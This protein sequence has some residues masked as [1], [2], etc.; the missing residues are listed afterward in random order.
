MVIVALIFVGQILE[1]RARDRVGDAIRALLDLAPKTAR[2]ITSEGEEQDAPLS[3]IIKGDRLRVRPGDHVPVDGIVLEGTSFVD[4]SLITGEPLPVEKQAGDRVTSGTVNQNGSLIIKAEKVGHETMLSQIVDMVAKAQRSRAAIQS[5]AD[6]VAAYFVPTVVAI[7]L[8]AFSIWLWVGPAPSLS[9]ALIAAVSVLIIACPCSL[10]LATPMSIMTATGRGAQLGILI[11]DAEALELMADVDTLVIDKTGTLTEGRPR[12]SDIISL[13]GFND[14]KLLS[15]AASLEQGSEHPLAEAIVEAAKSNKAKLAKL[16]TFKSIT[17]QG[18]TGVISGKTVGLGNRALMENLGIDLGGSSKKADQLSL[19][20]KTAIYVAVDGHVAGLIALS[21][22]IKYNAREAI[23]EL[24]SSGLNI[25]MATGDNAK[26]AQSIANQLG[27]D[28]IRANLLPED[29]AAL[30]DEL[31]KAGRKV[32]MAGDG[33]NDAPA[34]ASAD[35]GIAMSTGADV[36]VESAGITLLKGD[37]AGIMK[38]RKLARATMRNIKQNLFFAFIYNSL[39][40]P[41][42]AGILYPL[43]GVLLSPM[44]AAAAM[45][46]SSVSVITNAL[47][48]R[49]AKL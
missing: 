12:L 31:H 46:L 10:G 23:Q 36:A 16:E 49:K 14:K 11:K 1:L 26:T 29:K 5:L 35:V 3:Q 43:L 15:L 37:I 38:A 8:L 47:R 19:K 39:G 13:N 17:G 20:G 44:L 9:F 2:R 40:V 28:D 6:R 45:S 30:V 25:I 4:E 32:V 41:I 7:A 22:P 27:I 24:R 33:V 34:L 21:D 42:A 18:V 48:L